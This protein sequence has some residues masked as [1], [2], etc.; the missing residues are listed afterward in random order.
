[1]R[2]S[3]GDPVL[4]HTNIGRELIVI[5]HLHH[6]VLSHHNFLFSASVFLFCLEFGLHGLIFNFEGRVDYSQQQVHQ[7]ESS[8]ENHRQ[9]KNESEI[10]IRLLELDHDIGPSL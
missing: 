9:E 7:K 8:N 5:T 4:L 10:C 1:M 2:Y 6:V 3:L